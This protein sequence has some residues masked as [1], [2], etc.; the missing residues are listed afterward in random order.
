MTTIIE[1]TDCALPEVAV[2]SPEKLISAEE[3][4]DDSSFS[5]VRR[6]AMLEGYKWD[7]QVG[8]LTALASFPL[9]I[10]QTVWNQLAAHAEALTAEA[11]AAEKE[12]LE[13]PELLRLLGLPSALRKVFLD[14]DPLTP[15]AGRIIRFDFHPTTAGWRISEANSDVPGGFTESSHFTALMA[16]HYPL[17]RPAGNPAETWCDALAASAGANAHI[18][19]LSATPILEDHQVNAYLAARLRERGCHTHLAKPEQ[20]AWHNGF[21]HLDATWYRGPLA[22]IVRFYQAEWL[23]KLRQHAGWRCFFRGGQTPVANPPSAV[24][25][26]SKRFPLAWDHLRTDL[27]TWRKLLPATLDPRE[28]SSFGD[29]NWLLKAAYCNN[30]EAVSMPQLMNP[31]HWRAIQWRA[32]LWPGN[33]VAQQR[34]ESIPVA[35]PLGPR[36]VCIGVYTVNGEAAGVYARLAEKPLMDYLAM[37]VALLIDD[38]EHE[39]NSNL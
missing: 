39:P 37:D 2:C 3:P 14:R 13:R 16:R 27:P 25:S 20:I 12:I 21:A 30:G 6:Q 31:R 35:T 8:D 18:A 4:I 1:N 7:S 32:R 10:K 26:E 22:S 11:I 34:F 15:A 38:H 28:V 29:D 19:L 5:A 36:H 24:L 33:W 17:L 23:P 9:V